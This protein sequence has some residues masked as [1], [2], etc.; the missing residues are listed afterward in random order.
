MTIEHFPGHAESAILFIMCAL[1]TGHAYGSCSRLSSVPAP[2]CIIYWSVREHKQPTTVSTNIKSSSHTGRACSPHIPTRRITIIIV[3]IF[4]FKLILTLSPR[5]L[6]PQLMHT[7][8]EMV[9]RP[10]SWKQ[11][12]SF[13]LFQTHMVHLLYNIQFALTFLFP[14]SHAHTHTDYNNPPHMCEG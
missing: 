4:I 8:M 2:S 3:R 10:Y 7:S 14:S 1:N 11:H 9:F 5:Y 13:S 6:G 12:S